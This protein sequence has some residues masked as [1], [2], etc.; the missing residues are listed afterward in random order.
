MTV[1]TIN[2]KS[3]K[4]FTTRVYDDKENISVVIVEILL[5]DTFIKSFIDYDRDDDYT[6]IEKDLMQQALTYINNLEYT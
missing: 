6:N 2:D 1:F 4:I 5:D 3:Y